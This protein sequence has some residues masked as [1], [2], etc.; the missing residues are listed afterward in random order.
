MEENQKFS[1]IARLKS[2][3]YA[4]NGLKLFFINEHNARIHFIAAVL[5][6]AL[7][8]YL[9]LS[10]L[11]WVAILAVISAVFVAEILNSSIEKLADVVAPEIHPKIKM[12]KDLAAGA[13]LVTA[14]LALATGALIFLPKLF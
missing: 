9:Q 6:I 4:F 13:V 8:V 12:V 10:P 14:L 7:A 2:F 3:K 11:E 5:A 1:I